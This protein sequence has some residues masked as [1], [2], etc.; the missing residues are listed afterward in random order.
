MSPRKP[1]KAPQA[2]RKD[3]S[4]DPNGKG[5]DLHRVIDSRVERKEYFEQR[6]KAWKAHHNLYA[7][8]FVANEG[9][10]PSSALGDLTNDI[11]PLFGQANFPDVEDYEVIA[12]SL[13]LASRLLLH[14]SLHSMLRTIVG[15]GPLIP[16]G[17]SDVN[18]NPMYQ[19]RQGVIATTDEHATLLQEVWQQLTLFVTFRAKPGRTSH[20]ATTEMIDERRQPTKQ[21]EGLSSIVWY[22]PAVL[23]ILTKATV[24]LQATGDTPLLLAWRFTFAVQLAHE[25]C[26]ALLFARDGHR[27][28]MATEPFFPGDKTAEVGFKMEDTL[29][30]GHFALMW[31]NNELNT[32]HALQ[33]HLK[34]NG[35]PSDLVGIPVVWPWPS[36]AVVRAYQHHNCGLWIRAADL[37]ALDSHEVG[38]RVPLLDLSKFFQTAF[39]KH[40]DPPTRLVRKVG[41]AFQCDENGERTPYDVTERELKLLVPKGCKLVRFKAIVQKWLAKGGPA[42]LA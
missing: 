4:T 19:Y 5:L 18:N 2:H 24:N 8:D 37:E 17:E 25:A 42:K 13:R 41:F 39:W 33:C 32:E 40:P 12:P 1:A 30:G 38:W 28:A 9:A 14:P 10:L 36:P 16:L 3:P 7:S 23:E 35:E 11:L 22:S 20:D 31:N 21:L 34:P 15:H 6:H 29:F 27:D 26:H